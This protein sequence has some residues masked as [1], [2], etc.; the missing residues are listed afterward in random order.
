MPLITVGPRGSG[1]SGFFDWAHLKG[2]PPPTDHPLCRIL[3]SDNCGLAVFFPFFFRLHMDLFPIR[4]SFPFLTPLLF[5]RINLL[6]IFISPALTGV[7]HDKFCLKFSCV[8]EN[9][10]ISV[11]SS[12]Y[13]MEDSSGHRAD[14]SIIDLHTHTGDGHH[15]V[16][17][18]R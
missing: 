2:P 8:L 17:R 15:G 7:L 14:G 13:G 9:P 16:L 10:K 3:I 4:Y 11:G 6:C 12:S 18:P 1:L 5:D